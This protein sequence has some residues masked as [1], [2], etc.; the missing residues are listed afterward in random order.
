MKQKPLYHR[1]IIA[2]AQKKF[3]NLRFT[4]VGESAA[5]ISYETYVRSSSDSTPISFK[6]NLNYKLS[7]G[8]SGIWDYSEITLNTNEWV[9][10]WGVN[11]TP[12]SHFD[13][14]DEDMY[15]L[16]GFSTTG[17]LSLSGN[18]LSLAHGKLT[19]DNYNVI[20]QAYQNKEEYGFFSGLFAGTSVI[21]TPLL[22]GEL[23]VGCYAFMFY[24]CTA[25]T[26]AILDNTNSDIVPCA[27]WQT[28]AR[29]SVLNN[30]TNRYV[31]L[32]S[33]GS[34]VTSTSYNWVSGVASNGT[35][36]RGGST[37]TTRGASYIP[38]NWNIVT[39]S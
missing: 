39:I 32:Q 16:A 33:D 27:L 38:N 23:T 11:T 28:F 36:Y 12:I 35:F 29:C 7:N 22:Y 15:Q 34:A 18:L 17:T 13:S 14:Y 10:F 19:K 30:I 31:T 5:T 2:V 20:P 6:P 3:S 1:T 25:L 9:E 8:E 26:T 24:K 4:N 37:P 21:N